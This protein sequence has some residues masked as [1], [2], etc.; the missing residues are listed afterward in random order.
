MSSYFPG[1]PLLFL[2]T[3]CFHPVC[4]RCTPQK[5]IDF[6]QADVSTQDDLARLSGK[7]KD[8]L[9]NYYDTWVDV[10][11]LMSNYTE[12]KTA[13]PAMGSRMM[14]K[15]ASKL[16][17]LYGSM[18]KFYDSGTGGLRF[19]SRSEAFFYAGVLEKA[20]KA[21]EDLHAYAQEA[22]FTEKCLDFGTCDGSPPHE[23]ASCSAHFFN[24]IIILHR[25]H[26]NNPSNATY[27]YR[28]ARE[29]QIKGVHVHRWPS[30]WQLGIEHWSGLRSQPY[31][32]GDDE[33][34]LVGFLKDHYATIKK[35]FMNMLDSI[36]A[37]Q[38][39][40]QDNYYLT[41][42][43]DWSKVDIFGG[44]EWQAVCGNLPKTCE[45]LQSRPEVAS[46][47]RGLEEQPQPNG[48]SIFR[49]RPGTRLKP[50][51]GP[52]NYRLLCH[53]GL[54]VPEGP[55]LKVGQGGLRRWKEGEVLC[56]DDSYVHEAGHDGTKD[57]FV[58]MASMWHPDLTA[59]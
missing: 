32:E 48:V 7:R 39:W 22:F 47:P 23:H 12:K 55:W 25:H 36:P 57:R 3:A 44:G 11:A 1:L 14:K 52:A 53:L 16:K 8:K 31:W 58:L 29:T 35:E 27:W 18:V 30:E 4:V 45:L 56:F 38:P 59:R 13:N 6:L 26:L 20:A 28:V 41:E 15:A 43:G 2:W 33:L 34:P 46:Y 50:H 5:L 40:P 17:K 37:D 19:E 9:R 10:E 49:L 21:H 54:V 51:A 42:E 24:R